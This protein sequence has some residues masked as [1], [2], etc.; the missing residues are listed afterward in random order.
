[1]KKYMTMGE[2]R[3]GGFL[4]NPNVPGC[5]R[6]PGHDQNKCCLRRISHVKK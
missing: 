4:L 5:Q 2:R 3:Y 1:M 6:K